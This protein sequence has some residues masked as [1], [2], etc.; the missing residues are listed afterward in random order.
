[1]MQVQADEFWLIYYEY[2]DG[3]SRMGVNITIKQSP[4]SWL[5][6]HRKEFPDDLVMLKMA[7]KI[8]EEEYNAL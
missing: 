8:T 6:K 3:Q 4:A 7:L 5:A 1:M 2:S